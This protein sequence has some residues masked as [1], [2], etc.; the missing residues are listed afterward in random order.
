MQGFHK[1]TRYQNK[2]GLCFTLANESGVSFT[3][4]HGDAHLTA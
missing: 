4:G 3:L 1:H 2:R